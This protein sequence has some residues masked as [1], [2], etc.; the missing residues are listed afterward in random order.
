MQEMSATRAFPKESALWDKLIYD[1]V[2]PTQDLATWDQLTEEWLLRTWI[3][4]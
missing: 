3:H 4:G 1:A 2:I